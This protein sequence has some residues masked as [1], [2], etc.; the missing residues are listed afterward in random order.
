MKGEKPF[1]AKEDVP[2]WIAQK[3]IDPSWAEWRAEN[4]WPEPEK[5]LVA[6]F[7]EMEHGE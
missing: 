7:L 2:L 4:G 5:S 6:R 1:E 3:A